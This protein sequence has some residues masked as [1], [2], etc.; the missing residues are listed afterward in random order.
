MAPPLRADAFGALA[1]G[2]VIGH[3]APGKTP[4]RSI[5]DQCCDFC[6]LGLRQQQKRTRFFFCKRPRRFLT[7]GRRQNFGA[8]G[9]VAGH[10]LE[11]PHAAR[12][13]TLAQCVDQ[14]R[15]TFRRVALRPRALPRKR[16]GMEG[17]AELISICRAGIG[18]ARV[19]ASP[20]A[21]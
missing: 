14:S 20:I 9:D 19:M 1:A 6:R 15:I 18:S 12:A 5:G 7:V 2:D 11:P 8:L 21:S 16:G 13:E 3:T 10:R 4:W 17:E